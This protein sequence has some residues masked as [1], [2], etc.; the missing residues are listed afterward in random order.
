MVSKMDQRTLRTIDGS[1]L[2]GGGQVLRVAAACAV[3][4]QHPVTINKIRARRSAP[5]LKS[6]H[7][8]G[9]EVLCLICQGKLAGGSLNS[10]EVTVTPGPI[11]AGHFEADIQTAGSVML[12]IQLVLPCCL[13]A[14]GPTSL[15]L[16][17][18]TDTDMAPPVDY[19]KNVFAPIA[20]KFGVDMSIDVTRRGFF[21]RGGGEIQATI[22]NIP[23]SLTAVNLLEFG[24]VLKVEGVCVIADLPDHLADTAIDAAR[25][26]LQRG[27]PGAAD[28][29][30]NIKK[31]VTSY[32][33]AVGKGFGIVLWLRTSTDV[34]LGATCI[35]KAGKRGERGTPA[36]VVGVEAAQALIE[37][38]KLGACVDRHMQDQM[39][40]LMGLA[41][42]KSSVVCGPLT[43]HT[44]TAIEIMQQ[45]TPVKFT[46]DKMNDSLFKI[47]CDGIGMKRS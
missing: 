26:T 42:G 47:S 36:D 3:I 5:G 41:A 7:L 46:V 25:A 24:K 37:D 14:P 38:C 11:N 19:T 30:I 28:V 39:I 21:P 2:E 6:Q 9:L 31:E 29:H 20:S 34:V 22:K 1:L 40:L 44:L 43:Q 33:N 12:I 15:S 10:A 4:M 23:G 45:S 17:G 27:L 18:G 32:P 35:S 13:Y 16:R 8:K